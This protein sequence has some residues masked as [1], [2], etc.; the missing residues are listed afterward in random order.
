M[1]VLRITKG[2]KV[3]P[4]LINTDVEDDRLIISDI[5]KEYPKML[6]IV[7]YH[8]NYHLPTAKSHKPPKKTKE[9]RRQESIDRS[10]RRTRTYISDL[11]TSNQ[12]DLWCTFTFN[13]MKVDRYN[14]AACKGMM[15]RWLHRQSLHS[16]NMKY[17][18]VPEYHK[19]CEEC[20]NSKIDICNHNDRPKALHF[21]AL[22]SNYNGRL[23]NSGVRSRS[24]PNQ[25]VYN[26]TG[27]RAGHTD[28]I[29]IGEY[30][31]VSEHIDMD[32]EMEKIGNYISKYVTK[33]MIPLFAQKR[34]WCSQNLVR[35][36]THINGVSKYNLWNLVRAVKPVFVNSEYEMFNIPFVNSVLNNNNQTS[37]IDVKS[38][39]TNSYVSAQSSPLSEH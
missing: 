24:N 27:Y 29:K 14:A 36:T 22:I 9:E 3:D 13:K 19:K 10:I 38:T 15:S 32:R 34:Y 30:I 37:L 25:W 7:I 6:Q 33:D 5:V 18:I 4:N 1:Y 23:K 11:I 31:E 26:I 8:N 21:H 35:P 39:T 20:S 28:V 17:V 2:Y 12:F 16:P